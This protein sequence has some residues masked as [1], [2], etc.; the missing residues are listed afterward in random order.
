PFAGRLD[1]Y[2]WQRA[3]EVAA[4]ALLARLA[5]EE[6]AMRL[7][8]LAA[9]IEELTAKRVTLLAQEQTPA[10]QIRRLDEEINRKQAQLNAAVARL[11]AGEI[12]A[13][14]SA[15]WLERDEEISPDMYVHE[16]EF[17]GRVADSRKCFI[18]AY[19]TADNLDLLAEGI[20][21]WFYPVDGSAPRRCRMQARAAAP[22]LLIEHAGLV[23]QNSG[24]IAALPVAGGWRPLENIFELRADLAAE[25]SLE[26]PPGQSGL[27]SVRTLPRSLLGQWLQYL[28]QALVWPF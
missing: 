11:R 5:D 25:Q 26:L 20:E 16:G 2:A 13:L 28:W 14:A 21:A 6:G 12:K 9:Q 3:G 19:A 10:A 22:T 27:L 8:I 4:G 7:R 15:K 17:L 23:G 1:F 24:P 18:I